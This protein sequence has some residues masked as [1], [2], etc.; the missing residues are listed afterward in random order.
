MEFE[1]MQCIRTCNDDNNMG[2]VV[3]VSKHCSRHGDTMSD[4]RDIMHY[5]EAI[6]IGCFLILQNE[7]SFNDNQ[8]WS[9]HLTSTAFNFMIKF[10]PSPHIKKSTKPQEIKKRKLTSGSA[11]FLIIHDDNFNNFAVSVKELSEISF[12]HVWGQSS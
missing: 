8:E 4:Y 1:W 12:S 6:V 3:L 9:R 5:E 11:T 7:G 2:E 10:A